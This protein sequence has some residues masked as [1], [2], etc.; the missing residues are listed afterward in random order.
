[1]DQVYNFNKNEGPFPILR[2]KRETL[3]AYNWSPNDLLG[4]F[5]GLNYQFYHVPEGA[6][7]FIRAGEARGLAL[8]WRSRNETLILDF[9]EIF[10]VRDARGSPLV[11]GGAL[12][13]PPSVY[14]SP[15][16]IPISTPRSPQGRSP[17]RSPPQ[18]S[19][20]RYPSPGSREL[21]AYSSPRV[22]VEPMSPV[23]SPL[24][25]TR[26]FSSP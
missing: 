6:I 10:P 15:N 3:E 16:R 2:T 26:L 8:Y 11:Q 7:V 22:R 14:R 13:S 21:P 23:G 18:G 17:Q 24:Q 9:D 4:D 5:D 20:P 1:M 25:P 12:V 19:P